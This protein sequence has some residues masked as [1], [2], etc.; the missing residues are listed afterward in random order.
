MQNRG[1]IFAKK[2]ESWNRHLLDALGLQPLKRKNIKESKRERERGKG[3][4]GKE[5]EGGRAIACA[6]AKIKNAGTKGEETKGV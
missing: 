4:E 2:K 6:C 5:W 3:S 1:C